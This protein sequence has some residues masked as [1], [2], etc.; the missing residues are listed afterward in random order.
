MWEAIRANRRRS[1]LLI[2]LMG[3]VLVALGAMVGEVWAPHRG[4]VPG[5]GVALIVWLVLVL[6]AF[7]GGEQVLLMSAGAR[8]I[9]K[10]DAPRL[11]NV[12]EEMT[13][14][15]ALPKMPD[16]YVVDDATPNAF[17]VGRT[18]DRA[19]VA[20]TTGLLKR[21]NRDEL[22]GVVAHEIGHIKNLDIRFMTLAAVM[23]GAIV[24]IADVFLRSLWYGGAARRRGS[25]ESGQ[26]QLVLV[27][28]AVAVA[29]LA[30][31]LA[32]LLYFACSR[33]REYLA[34]ASS[35]RFTRYPEGLASALEKI[36]GGGASRSKPNR[37][38]APLYIVNPAQ[39]MALTGL[40]STHPPTAKRIEILRKMAGRAGYADYESAYRAVEGTGTALLDRAVLGEGSVPARA[41]TPEPAR[42]AEAVARVRE[43]TDLLDRAAGMLLVACPCGVRL[44]VPA[45]LDRHRITC[46]RCGREHDVPAARPR[47]DPGG[48]LTYR[49]Q[50]SDAWE[51]FRC[52]CGRTQQLSP[53]FRGDQ[54]TCKGCGREIRIV[55]PR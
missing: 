1:T 14:A 25:R 33:Q 30:P 4:A 16:V 8:K 31:I 54:M 36:A 11:W 9:E 45:E 44:K 50:S 42:K 46:P 7:A 52:A 10:K 35:A 47:D 39:G 15:A 34:D 24:L 22:Q 49:R 43:V 19:A 21:L 3:G 2:G 41:A 18:P 53:A 17:A 51:S 23:L 37:A 5:A 48:P 20:V 32:R 12:V 26:A 13:I 40:F 38:L 29:V 6:V 28:I 55:G 27:A